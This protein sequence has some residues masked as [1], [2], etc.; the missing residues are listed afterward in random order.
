MD[1]G[2]LDRQDSDEDED[3]DEEEEPSLCSR[4][5]YDRGKLESFPAS[6]FSCES[7]GTLGPTT[8]TD[9]TGGGGCL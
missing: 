8:T 6:V 7:L 3:E 4:V 5:G 1:G 2:D 9:P